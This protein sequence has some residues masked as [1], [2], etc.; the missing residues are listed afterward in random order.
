MERT[1]IVVYKMMLPSVTV[2]RAIQALRIWVV[3]RFY[4]VRLIAN[5]RRRPNVIMGYAHVSSCIKHINIYMYIYIQIILSNNFIIFDVVLHCIQWNVTWP[6]IVLETSC[7]S[8]AYVN[9]RATAIP[10][11]QN[12]NIVKITFVS[13]NCDV[14]TAATARAHKFVKQTRSGR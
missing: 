13:K 8:E 2:K 6:E 7:V 1:P 9:R 14:L 4:T 10:A 12:F 3:H 11:V 5:V